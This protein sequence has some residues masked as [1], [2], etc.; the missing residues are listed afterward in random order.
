MGKGGG[1]PVGGLDVVQALR[2]MVLAIRGPIRDGVRAA[3][4][5]FCWTSVGRSDSNVETEI[6]RS[7][8]V[9]RPAPR[10]EGARCGPGRGRTARVEAR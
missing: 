5:R 7:F 6:E 9:V 4:S 2:L 3:G 1:A 8:P 10:F